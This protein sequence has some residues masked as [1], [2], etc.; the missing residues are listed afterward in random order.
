MPAP[1]FD[2]YRTP[3]PSYAPDV[4][5]IQR[6][7][8][9]VLD[10]RDR[11][12]NGDNAGDITSLVGGVNR[13]LDMRDALN[14]GAT[15]APSYVGGTGTSNV[16]FTNPSPPAPAPVMAPP[17][18]QGIRSIAPDP[19]AMQELAAMLREAERRHILRNSGVARGGALGGY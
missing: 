5:T 1:T 7:S 10:Q 14:P 19:A 12:L 11:I 9:G 16:G 3:A 4:S 15:M 13:G 17:A 18:P 8:S 2:A 6:Q